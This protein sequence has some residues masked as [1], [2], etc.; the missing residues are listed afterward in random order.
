VVNLPLP[1]LSA[2]FFSSS[3]YFSP[4]FILPV[5]LSLFS[6]PSHG[7]AKLFTTSQFRR[8]DQYRDSPST[9]SVHFGGCQLYNAAS[10][11]YVIGRILFPKIVLDFLQVPLSLLPNHADLIRCNQRCSFV[12]SLS[13]FHDSPTT[14]P[15]SPFSCQPL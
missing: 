7:A 15:R 1:L 2:S 10:I 5:V 9:P 6:L 14:F 12:S 13:V 4:S 3:L 11:F 8:P